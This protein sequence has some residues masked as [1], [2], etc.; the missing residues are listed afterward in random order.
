MLNAIYPG[1]TEDL[2]RT[3]KQQKE[4]RMPVESKI[5]VAKDLQAFI[6]GKTHPGLF[7][8]ERAGL[9]LKEGRKWAITRQPNPYNL[10]FKLPSM[11]HPQSAGKPTPQKTMDVEKGN[12]K[13]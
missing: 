6:S 12:G 3:I 9:L 5:S 13:G 10:S 4:E 8:D 11:A 2:C 1:F 7:K